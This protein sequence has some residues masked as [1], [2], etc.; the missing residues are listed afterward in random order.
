MITLLDGGV[1]TSLWKL[2][3]EAGVEKTTVW[4]YNIEHPELVKKLHKN[5][6]AAGSQIILANTFGANRLMVERQSKY[7]VEQVVTAGVKLAK[8]A[9]AGTDVKVAVAAGPLSILLE[10][11]GD[12][13]EDEAFEIFDEQIG[14]GVK[15]G[16]DYVM[17]Q[18]FI[19]LEMMKV[20]VKAAKQYGV[21]V[22]TS[23]SFE[24]NGKTI[25][26]QSVADVCRELELLRVDAVGANC[27]F[28]P[29]LTLP[30]IEE[31]S[32]T[33]KLPLLLK[34][35]AGLPVKNP[36][37]SEASPYTAEMFAAEIRPA[38]NYVSYIGGCC[39]TDWNYIEAIRKEIEFI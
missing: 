3:E 24:K 18:T 38:L 19:D 32:K 26:G 30:I 23:L 4:K 25:M 2:A 29:E 11:Y 35:N 10:P 39:N 17:I 7:T 16:A 27:S 14:N 21:P 5:L 28:G 8:E 37:G 33:T 31:F 9:A 13:E 1:G 6:I 34:P 36:D 15:A 20:A 22:L 12:L